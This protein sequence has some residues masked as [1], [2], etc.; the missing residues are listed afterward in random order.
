[1]SSTE[2]T[3]TTN[4]HSNGDYTVPL[5]ING[6]EK[7]TSTT[8]DVVSPENGNVIHKC[9]SAS[10]ED[11]KAAVDAAAAAFHSWKTTVPKQR[12]EIF[13]KTAEI[14]EKRRTELVQYLMEETG[15]NSVWANFNLDMAIDFIKDIAGRVSTIQGLLPIADDKN[16][17]GM[18]LKEPYGVVLAIAPW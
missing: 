3:V 13:L 6:V 17:T 5:L 12:R 15:G 14:M 11:A 9:S 7:I 4:G 18:I 16:R 10:V 8:F 1:M 2:F